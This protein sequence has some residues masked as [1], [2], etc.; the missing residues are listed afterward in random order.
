MHITF[1]NYLQYSEKEKHR[2]FCLTEVKKCI[3]CGEF[4]S[5]E[6]YNYRSHSNDGTK[7]E[8]RN[9]C[10]ACV[11]KQWTR[12]RD[13][14]KKHPYPDDPFYKCPICKH[15]QEEIKFTGAFHSKTRSKNSFNGKHRT[16]NNISANHIKWQGILTTAKDTIG[17]AYNI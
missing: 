3:K 7:T 6:E 11:K 1:E 9:D 12:V 13:L 5:L 10:K 14:K 15:T 16:L 4:K 17:N 8:Q 2:I